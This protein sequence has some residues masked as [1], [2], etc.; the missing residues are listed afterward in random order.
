MLS[1]YGCI[2]E[3][4]VLVPG[5]S[6]ADTRHVAG[7]VQA[8]L[9][10]IHP[11]VLEFYRDCGAEVIDES[12]DQDST[13]LQKCLKSVAERRLEHAAVIAAGEL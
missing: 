5:C 7:V 12:H 1:P 4:A 8:T 10:S 9:D 11:E 13:D 2:R 3:S 6:I